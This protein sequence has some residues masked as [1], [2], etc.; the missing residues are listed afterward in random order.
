MLTRH[1]ISETAFQ[2]KSAHVIE[3]RRSSQFRRIEL[4]LGPD[5]RSRNFFASRDRSGRQQRPGGRG[6][7]PGQLVPIEQ[8]AGRHPDASGL[9]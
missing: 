3:G 1:K 4:G 8:Q 6:R 9:L 7:A 2:P 5:E